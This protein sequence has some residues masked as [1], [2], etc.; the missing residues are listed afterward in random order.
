MNAIERAREALLAIEP[1]NRYRLM[2]EVAAIITELLEPYGLR[3]VVVG[4][5]AVEIYTRGHYTTCDID[6]VVSCRDVAGQIISQLGFI[7]EG[8]H[9]YHEKLHVSIEMPGDRLEDADEE[10]VIKLHLPS[11]RHLYVIGIEDIILDRLRACVYWK[12]SS[13]CEWGLRLLKVHRE[14]LDLSYMLQ[15]VRKEGQVLEKELIKWLETEPR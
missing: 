14:R 10:K 8:R 11:G 3:P 1:Q 2:V 5:L 7:K 13:D 6:L 15:S 4:G 12:S 9:W